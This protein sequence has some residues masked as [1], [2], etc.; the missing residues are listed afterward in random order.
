MLFL[1]VV[2]SN[3]WLG[4]D[5]VCLFICLFVCFFKYILLI[6]DIFVVSLGCLVIY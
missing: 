4:I 3:A 1:F 2:G 6:F 5:F